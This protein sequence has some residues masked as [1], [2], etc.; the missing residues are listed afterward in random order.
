MQTEKEIDFFQPLFSEDIE[1]KI[2]INQ[3]DRGYSLI[4]LKK[5]LEHEMFIIE[6]QILEK[7]YTR[8]PF[9]IVRAMIQAQ[10][11]KEQVAYINNKILKEL[12]NGRIS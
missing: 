2:E 9:D 10:N 1:E 8:Q 3:R 6:R 12:L 5:L 7:M 11:L 4:E